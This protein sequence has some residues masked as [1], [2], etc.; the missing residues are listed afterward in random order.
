[1]TPR[2]E[3]SGLAIVALQNRGRVDTEDREQPGAAG[4]GAHRYVSIGLGEPR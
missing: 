2:G 1:M 3:R 4:G